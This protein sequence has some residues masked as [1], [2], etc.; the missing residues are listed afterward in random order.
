MSET[1]MPTPSPSSSAM[2]KR[3]KIAWLGDQRYVTNSESGHQLI[4]DNSKENKVGMSPVEALLGALATC[5]M[6]DVV[7]IMN[8]RHTPLSRYHVE[9]Y[10]KRQE[11]YPRRFTHITLTHVAAGEGVDQGQLERAV[12]MSHDKYCSIVATLNCPV[13]TEVRFE[14]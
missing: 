11:E 2:D 8:K 3:V 5:S 7:G 1:N 13:E 4:L 12:K 6:Y 10:G 9:A 14:Q